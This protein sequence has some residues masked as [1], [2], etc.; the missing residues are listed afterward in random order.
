MAGD[1]LA[2]LA[3]PP[4]LP[5][6]PGSV[7][8]LLLVAVLT[9]IPDDR[10]LQQVLAEVI[11]VLGPGGVVDVSDVV[12]QTDERNRVRDAAEVDRSGAPDG[13]FTTEDGAMLRHR[14][15]AAW[16]ELFRELDIVFERLL[17]V[18]TMNGHRAR[19][20]QLL[21]RTRA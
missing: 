14:S 11:R 5:H 2:V 12:L 3:E 18:D 8:V 13:T 1:R 17:D 16:R 4:T 10:Q 20:V 9:C 15:L 19:A 21:A 7:D 6:Q